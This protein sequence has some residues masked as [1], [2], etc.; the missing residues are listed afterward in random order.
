MPA[1]LLMLKEM[2]RHFPN[3]TGGVLLGFRSS[4]EDWIIT[5]IV[6]PG[7]KAIHGR[8]HFIPDYEFH[9]NE[10]ARIYEASNCEETYL[11]DWHTHPGASAYTSE[12]DKKTLKNIFNAKDARLEEPIMLIIGTSPFELKGWSYSKK[13][14][15]YRDFPNRKIQ[16]LFR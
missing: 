7:P 16:I 10:V 9:R 3:E 5:R 6:G 8:Y 13:G 15:P 12:R 4:N 14:L 2:N 1:L 11:G